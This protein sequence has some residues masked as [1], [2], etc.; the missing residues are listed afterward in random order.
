VRWWLSNDFERTFV[1]Y[2]GERFFMSAFLA[3]QPKDMPAAKRTTWIEWL[4]LVL[5]ILFFI[6]ALI[7]II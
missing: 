4:L 6:S 3:G 2:S 1:E 5:A 7:L